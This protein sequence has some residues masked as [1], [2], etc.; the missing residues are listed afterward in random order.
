M[1][2]AQLGDREGRFGQVVEVV[3]PEPRLVDEHHRVRRRA[4]DQ[5]H[6]DG[7]V[8]RVVDGA[9]AFDEHPV[10][11]RFA[12]LDQ[13]FDGPI[14]EVADDP[15]YR[16][17]PALDHHP[18]LAGRHHH[19]R[20]PVSTGRR[21]QL[22][23]DR[24]LADGAIGRDGQDHPLARQRAA[25]RPPSPSGLVAGDSRRAWCPPQRLRPRTPGR[26]RTTRAAPSGCRVRRR[27]LPGSPTASFAATCRRS[28]RCR[29]GAR[30]AGSDPR[31]PHRASR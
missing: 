19:R 10:A 22:E 11:A 26:R 1:N 17:A 20:C 4:V 15:V 29:S 5:P 7:A 28:V 16:H 31:V 13:P 2:G 8:R 27:S 9:L 24:H 18:G 25:G 12:L 23:G 3:L 6:R 21:D 30:R 14:R